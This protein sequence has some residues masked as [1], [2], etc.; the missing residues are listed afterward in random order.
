MQGLAG[1]TNCGS[2]RQ[3]LPHRLNASHARHKDSLGKSARA[4]RERA[5]EWPDEFDQKQRRLRCDRAE[6]RADA[7]AQTRGLTSIP[8]CSVRDTHLGAALARLHSSSVRKSRAR[9][10][11]TRS[12]ER[13]WLAA[14]R[15]SALGV[16]ISASR[17]TDGGRAG[18]SSPN[19]S[20]VD[21]A[22][23]DAAPRGGE[24]VISRE[25]ETRRR[26]SGQGV[27]ELLVRH[28]NVAQ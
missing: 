10:L 17:P 14:A 7:R 23:G 19:E 18:S 24:R 3:P 12:A 25:R 1:A 2:I 13:T 8:R 16:L 21:V 9:S 11:G 5:H 28:C 22:A 27:S 26:R 4:L 6:P 20:A 15:C